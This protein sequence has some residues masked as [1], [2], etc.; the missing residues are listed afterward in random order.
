MGWDPERSL[1]AFRSFLVDLRSVGST[2]VEDKGEALERRLSTRRT[3]TKGLSSPSQEDISLIGV[4]G[5]EGGLIVEAAEE[6]TIEGEV[7]A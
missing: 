5:P 3:P 1:V 6:A 4:P 7:L 2:E